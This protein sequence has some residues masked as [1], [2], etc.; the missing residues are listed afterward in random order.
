MKEKYGRAYDRANVVQINR[1][2]SLF[3]W[4]NAFYNKEVDDQVKLFNETLTN[5]FRNYIPHKKIKCDYKDPPWITTE[6][7]TNLRKKKRLYKKNISKGRTD[8]DLQ[9]LNGQSELCSELINKSKDK[10][11]SNLANKLDDP[12]LGPKTYW[13]ILNGFLG[14]AKNSHHSAFTNK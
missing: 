3:D 11:F 6:I 4:E 14:K 8:D 9:S 12:F 13:K 1:A 7:K 5:I 2:I 10:H